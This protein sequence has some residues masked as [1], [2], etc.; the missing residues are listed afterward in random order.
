VIDPATLRNQRRVVG[1]PP[2]PRPTLTLVR[3]M[4]WRLGRASCDCGACQRCK[5]RE[6]MRAYRAGN[7]PPKGQPGQPLD[8]VRR[9][10][11]CEGPI[12]KANKTGFCVECQTRFVYRRIGKVAKSRSYFSHGGGI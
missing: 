2:R 12:A 4:A 5:N 8:P 11:H 1:A 7:P 9:C 6:W 10:T 3:P